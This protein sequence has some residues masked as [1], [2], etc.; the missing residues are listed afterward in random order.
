ME[1]YEGINSTN[2]FEACTVQ[3]TSALGFHNDAMNC[4]MID[5]TIACFIPCIHTETNERYC[6]SFLYYSMKCVEEHMI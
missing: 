6:L 2:I 4:P 5:N 1:Q 3:P